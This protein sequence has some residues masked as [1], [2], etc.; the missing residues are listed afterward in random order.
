MYSEKLHEFGTDVFHERLK[1]N[2]LSFVGVFN[3]QKPQEN[4][5]YFTD[6]VEGMQCD[7]V[8][9]CSFSKYSTATSMS[10]LV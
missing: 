3:Y 9:D 8:P 10:P 7:C 1:R 4:N 2:H 6:T 5:A